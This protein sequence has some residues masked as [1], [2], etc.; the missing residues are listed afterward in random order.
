MAGAPE[1]FQSSARWAE[2]EAAFRE[3]GDAAAVLAGLTAATD[4]I[5]REAYA[6][7]IE[8]SVPRSAAMFAVGAYGRAE[9]F[10]YSGA[11]LV[12]VVDGVSDVDAL[13]DA[14]GVFARVLWD[15]GLRLNY[16]V[17]TV[18]EC[19]D[20]REQ[21]LELA[22][23]LLD[24][25]FL[26]GDPDVRGRL[27]ERVPAALT[28]A[29]KKI[30]LRLVHSARVRHAKHGHT[31]QRLEPDVKEAPGGL[32]DLRLL[33]WLV[34]LF[35]D[36]TPAEALDTAARTLR[37]ARCFLHYRAGRDVNLLDA[38][39]QATLSEPPFRVQPADYFR[40]ARLIYAEARRALE[41]VE[42]SHSSLLDNF[43]DYRT[44]LSNGEFT[45][46]RDRL[47]L[48]SPAHLES[49]PELILRLGEFV[50]RHG[51]APAPETERRL[52]RCRDSLSA[53]FATSRPLWPALKQILAAPHAALALRALHDSD[54]LAA[55]LPAWNDV[56]RQPTANAGRVFTADE[57]AFRSL[58][59]VEALRS[60]SEAGAQRFA[61]VISEID[62]PAV[63]A[64]AILLADADPV[65]G[66][67][68]AAH[69]HMPAEDQDTFAFL[70]AHQ[71]GLAASLSRDIDDPATTAHLAHQAGTVERL[72][73][74]TI[75]TYAALAAADSD[76]ASKY[77]LDRLWKVY[78]AVRDKLTRE[79]ETERI[80]QPPAG[81]PEV[82]EFV[83]GFPSRYVRAHS[84][85]E[86]ATQFALYERS[87]PT[88]VAVD[89]EA[90]EGGYR[91]AVV[92]RDRPY[93]F[94]SFA[95]A[96][97]SFGLY[98]LKAEAFSNDRGVILDTFLFADPRRLLQ[99][100]PPE[101]ERLKDLVQRFVSGKTDAQRL[102][103]SVPPSDA[104]RR[105]SAPEVRFDSTAC[106]TAT[107][108]EITTDDRPGLLY[109]LATVFSNSACNIDVVLIDTK[110]RRAIDIFYVASDGHK[111]SPEMEEHL[112]EK[113]LAAC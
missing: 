13:R 55:L 106:E 18:A 41:V 95:A 84:A 57:H 12:I 108:V 112:R 78:N 64:L 74:L 44:R 66:A 27:D 47:L 16:S 113:L 36:A 87:R 82:A 81:L 17:R 63:L 98:I 102:M 30:A 1:K 94:A 90:A 6:S 76:A 46:G 104:K 67:G 68:T 110:G 38:A 107:L 99:L 111:L 32:R 40:A 89:L 22:I 19:V 49:D 4:A 109:S 60:A 29:S 73:L 5:V 14:K 33:D 37:V 23:S 101:V 26:A 100:N 77:R 24:R 25:R 79:L 86:I 20:I 69:I 7:S 83:R 45:V 3:S 71:N 48:R 34:K 10:P 70:L 58:E 39:A 65:H 54:L 15:A 105:V 103:R 96:I 9:T 88:G 31:A 80:E 35:P 85:A 11:D 21:N 61:T 43:R 93:L 51:I 2:I 59:A 50:A 97:S 62:Q 8:R 91:L 52:E 53:W 92:A 72:R 42:R 56:W 28:R 75:F